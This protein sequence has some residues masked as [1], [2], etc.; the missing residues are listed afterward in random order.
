M[1]WNIINHIAM[2]EIFPFPSFESLF[3]FR[4]IVRDIIFWPQWSY[5]AKKANVGNQNLTD[6]KPPAKTHVQE[7]LSNILLTHIDFRRPTLDYKQTNISKDDDTIGRAPLSCI[8]EF[9]LYVS[10]WKGWLGPL[11]SKDNTI[12]WEQVER[13]NSVQSTI[14]CTHLVKETPVTFDD[15]YGNDSNG[16]NFST[17]IPTPPPLPTAESFR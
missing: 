16:T 12:T 10:T 1:I 5:A 11:P 6:D 4:F 14:S 3:S 9:N 17:T 2:Y 13:E 15:G 7:S 8:E